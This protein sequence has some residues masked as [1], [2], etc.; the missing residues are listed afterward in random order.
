MDKNKTLYTLAQHI[1]LAGMLGLS[2]TMTSPALNAWAAD[3]LLH[4]IR[5]DQS[6]RHFIIDTTGAVKAKV[7]TLSIAGRKRVIIDLD[8]ADIGG[9]LPR[10]T[11]LLQDLTV[12]LPN[13][14]NVTVNQYG[15]NGRPIVRVLLDL[16]G[17]PGTVRLLR[18][19]GPRIELEFSD[20]ASGG[21]SSNSP[22]SNYPANSYSNPTSPSPS[23]S[24][25]SGR[26]YSNDDDNTSQPLVP[27]RT[28]SS[29][30]TQSAT[31]LEQMKRTLVV[32][33]SRYDKLEQENQSLKS[34]LASAQNTPMPKSS[35]ADVSRLQSQIDSL[36][37]RNTDL[38]NQVQSLSGKNADMQNRLTQALS[39]DNSPRVDDMKQTLVEMNHQY[40][41]LKQEKLLQAQQLD[42][43][44]RD[45]LSQSQQIQQLSQEKSSLAQQVSQLKAQTTLTASATATGKP[46]TQP[47]QSSVSDSEIQQLRHQ[48]STAQQAM[49]DSLK[50]I[51]EQNHEMEYLRN[52]VNT[53]KSGMDA[54]AKEQITSLQNANESKDKTISDLRQQ[55]SSLQ[56]VQSASA[57]NPQIASLKGQ[58]E[59]IKRQNQNEV[60]ALNHQLENSKAQ[61]DLETQTLNNQLQ[62]K[63]AQIENLRQQLNMVVDRQN[64]HPANVD[65]QQ[66]DNRIS[67]L[68]KELFQAKQQAGKAQNA[69]QDLTDAKAQLA[70][71]KT[72]EEQWQAAQRELATTKTQLAQAQANLKQFNATQADLAV[73]KAQ[74]AQVQSD[75]TQL[76]AA[77]Q[78]LTELK[79]QIE[80]IKANSGKSTQTQQDAQNRLDRLSKDNQQL[81]QQLADANSQLK[82][83][84]QQL[85]SRPD[86]SAQVSSLQKQVND[87]NQQLQ[88][89]N[90]Q[91]KLAQQRTTVKPTGGGSA[92]Q[93]S[94]LQAQ[95]S[96]LS[97]QIGNLRK[98]NDDLKS[99]LAS[100][101]TASSVTNPDAETAYQ[102]AKTAQKA[103]KT[104]DALDKYKAALLLD[105]NNSRYTIDYSVALSEDQ[106]YAE[107]IDVLRRYLQHNPMDREAYN[108]L[109]KIYLLNDQPDAANQSFMRAVPVS[110]L[111][112]YATSLKKL[113]K[114]SEAEEIFKVALTIN[115]KDSE[116]LFNLGN[117]YNN[118]NKLEQARNKYLEA[119]QIRPDFAEAHYN[120][121]LIFS[122]MGNNPKAVEHLEKFLQLSPNARNAET[123][124]AYVQKLK[125]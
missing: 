23:Y 48:L 115:P 105:P 100:R 38:S 63:T 68:E 98:E 87:L 124:R 28:D 5:F 46:V 103:K 7:N 125:A 35:T 73:T 32:M 88:Q 84:R 99:S 67:E 110:T 97:Q 119:I 57:V 9:D 40:D 55:I 21:L 117:L 19:Q 11:Q 112:N 10:D 27:S 71:L 70:Q 34:K 54:A 116:V 111:N 74:L 17:D 33:N 86:D 30:T 44:K 96:S 25:G 62:D 58:I 15:G 16:Q 101:P 12:Q 26:S 53:V 52:Q 18:T 78:Q 90:A 75:E 81:S 3:G 6:S 106:Q 121:G 36:N 2:L 108:Q 114:L 95:V 85:A 94:Q 37:Q 118:Q 107:A 50:T 104:S 91:L 24:T 47:T 14:K 69:Q 123:I 41:Q 39:T 93:A 89:T 80:Q 45:R 82:E 43:M 76:K 77:R 72:N 92:A 59:T 65:L 56:A 13:L 102:E 60:Q 109:G 113:G 49:T 122:K 61:H 51:Q 20:Y 31:Q 4:N 120:L 29:A 42:Q 22:T 83:T 8:N 79:S 64:N 66:K 1:T